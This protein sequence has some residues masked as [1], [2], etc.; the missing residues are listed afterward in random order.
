MTKKP[1]STLKAK[2][3]FL[4]YCGKWVDDRLVHYR[5]EGVPG[6]AC[7]GNSGCI[8]GWERKVTCPKCVPIVRAA[9]AR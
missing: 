2:T 3:L 4:N 5:K 6:N 7:G 1:E 8:T 9:V